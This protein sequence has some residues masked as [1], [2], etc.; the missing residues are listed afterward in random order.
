MDVLFDSL[1]QYAVEIV[2]IVIGSLL[3][4][5]L[6][7]V[8]KYVDTLKKKDETKIIDMI[9]DVVVDYTEAELKGEKGIVKRDF[10]VA[11]VVEILKEKGIQAS[12]EEIIAGIENGVK[13]LNAYKIK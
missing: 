12:T 4:I 9:T 7:R 11:K 5:V 2:V 3:S 6:D 1:F 10:A 13:K 8:K